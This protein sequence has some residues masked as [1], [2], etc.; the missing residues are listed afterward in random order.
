MDWEERKIDGQMYVVLKQFLVEEFGIT[1]FK[2][3]NLVSFQTGS[4]PLNMLKYKAIYEKCSKLI[5]LIFISL[6]RTW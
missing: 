2:A 4:S 3:A 1:V 5:F 6:F